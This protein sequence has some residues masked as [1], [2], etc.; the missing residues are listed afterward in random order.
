MNEQLK[1]QGI[2]LLEK[3]LANQEA[4][5]RLQKKQLAMYEAQYA[6]AERNI[7]RAEAL[8]SRAE[9]IQKIVLPLILLLLVAAGW[10]VWR[11]L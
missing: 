11:W 7:E 2:T 6:K 9:R 8:Q 1:Q 5:L 3:I 10:L 4:S